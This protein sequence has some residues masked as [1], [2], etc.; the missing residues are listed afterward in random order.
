VL[1]LAGLLCDDLLLVVFFVRLGYCKM[2][3]AAMGWTVFGCSGLFW[4]VLR[5]VVLF[6]DVVFKA[7]LGCCGLKYSC[8]D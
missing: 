8:M 1:L 5:S 7:G 3:Y 6:W 4:A 2:V